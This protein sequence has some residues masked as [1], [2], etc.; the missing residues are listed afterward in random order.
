MGGEWFRVFS[1]AGMWTFDNTNQA[2]MQQ[3]VSSLGGSTSIVNVSSAPQETNVLMQNFQSYNDMSQLPVSSFEPD[4]YLR[5]DGFDQVKPGAAGAS[6][7]KFDVYRY[8]E[9]FPSYGHSLVT[10]LD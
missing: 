3:I 6:T 7:S 5:N 1:D 10:S 9:H 4:Q 2:Q 8:R